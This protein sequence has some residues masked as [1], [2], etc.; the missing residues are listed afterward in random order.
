[1]SDLLFTPQNNAAN[2]SDSAT[3]AFEVVEST[4]LTTML[5]FVLSNKARESFVYGSLWGVKLTP[6]DTVEINF[7]GAE[8]V[9]TGSHLDKLYEQLRD[10]KVIRIRE[11][12]RL[13]E[14]QLDDTP[15]VFIKKIEVTYIA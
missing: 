15:K 13:D 9:I 8:V 3:L 6:D 5:E 12:Q 7:T 4:T 2:N 10:R 1:M 11:S 14:I